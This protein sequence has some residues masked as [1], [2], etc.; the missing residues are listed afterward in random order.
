MKMRRILYWRREMAAKSENESSQWRGA[1]AASASGGGLQNKRHQAHGALLAN[2][3]TRSGVRKA[4]ATANY[5][6]EKQAFYLGNTHCE[7]L[8][9]LKMK[10]M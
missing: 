2:A 7:K 1:N 3:Q 9:E 10:N 6:R 4:A 8:A 5:R